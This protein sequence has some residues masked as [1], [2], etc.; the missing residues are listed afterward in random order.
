MA[1]VRKCDKCE[2]IDERQTWASAKEA[3]DAGAF[4]QWT[5]PTCAWTEFDLVETSE[6]EAATTR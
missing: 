2:H 4:Q 6:A 5:C 3:A 1:V